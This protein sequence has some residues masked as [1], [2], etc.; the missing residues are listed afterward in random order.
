MN[1][2]AVSLK[3]VMHTCAYYSSK[4]LDQHCEVLSMEKNQSAY[5][6]GREAIIQMSLHTLTGLTGYCIKNTL[7]LNLVVCIITKLQQL[8]L[9]LSCFI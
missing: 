6:H 4:E 9:E 1:N 3:L 8:C 5:K 7:V 2:E